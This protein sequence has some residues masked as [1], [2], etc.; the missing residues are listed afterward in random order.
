MSITKL[1]PN[2]ACQMGPIHLINCLLSGKAT[3][4]ELFQWRLFCRPP[5]RYVPLNR[6]IIVTDELLYRMRI[7]ILR[8]WHHDYRL[9]CLGQLLRH[10]GFFGQN[11]TSLLFW[12][13]L[14]IVAQRTIADCDSCALF[15]RIILIRINWD[16]SWVISTDNYLDQSFCWL[17]WLRLIFQV[18]RTRN[19]CRPVWKRKGHQTAERGGEGGGGRR[20]GAE[21][22]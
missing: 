13:A 6:R 8:H 12:S 19:I 9:W 3:S 21:F 5:N 7:I 10:S 20:K 14:L 22:S 15:S 11:T 4:T 18:L 17:Y 16:V 1:S 2:W